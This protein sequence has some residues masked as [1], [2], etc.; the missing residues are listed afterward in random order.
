[1]D[2]VATALAMKGRYDRVYAGAQALSDRQFHRDG[3]LSAILIS[4]TKLILLLHFDP[5]SPFH[6]GLVS[7][8]CL[9]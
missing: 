7:V 2:P 8:A 1:M 3:S 4:P 9:K 6:F 5:L